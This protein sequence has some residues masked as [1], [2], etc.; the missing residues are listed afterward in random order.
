MSQSR[1][2]A[3]IMFTDVVGYSA[4]MSK[5]ESK[6]FEVLNSNR[7]IQK[8]LIKRF[9]GVWLKEMGDGV[10]AS[11]S[12]VT[13]AVFCAAAIQQACENVPDLQLR[14]GRHVHE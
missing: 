13:D 9:K 3:A 11:F 2:L 6:A 1:Q 14:I 4:L 7:S 10:L 12:T 5:D 8:P